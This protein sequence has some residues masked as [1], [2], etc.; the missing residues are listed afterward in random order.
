VSAPLCL[1]YIQRDAAFRVTVDLELEVVVAGTFKVKTEMLPDVGVCLRLI[2]GNSNF[3]ILAYRLED[4]PHV[5]IAEVHLNRVA[6]LLAHFKSELTC[7]C[8]QRMITGKRMSANRVKRSQN[9]QFAAGHRGGITK[10]ENF[11]LHR[12]NI[13][14]PKKR[15]EGML[16]AKSWEWA[17]KSNLNLIHLR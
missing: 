10:C 11:S 8:T 1:D 16:S 12:A 14:M 15:G 5:R 4:G 2:A 6:A 3:E 17:P 13:L 9:V 7:N